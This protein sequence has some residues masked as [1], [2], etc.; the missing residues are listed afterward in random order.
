MVG[1]DVLRA[2]VNCVPR[3]MQTEQVG[4]VRQSCERVAMQLFASASIDI[5]TAATPAV[6]ICSSS[7][8]DIRGIRTCTSARSTEWCSAI[9]SSTVPAT[10]TS[11]NVVLPD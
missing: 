11:T 1:R 6:T 5:P 2:R 8:R 4:V 3:R 7:S 9:N 10:P